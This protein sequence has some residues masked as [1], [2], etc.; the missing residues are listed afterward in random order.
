MSL[1]KRFKIAVTLDG[2]VTIT[3]PDD[4]LL[5]SQPPMLAS[6]PQHLAR[7]SEHP[8]LYL[9]EQQDFWERDAFLGLLCEDGQDAGEIWQP[10]HNI[11]KT[12]THNDGDL[13]AM[14]RFLFN[15]LIGDAAWKNIEDLVK[16]NDQI[17]LSLIFDSGLEA[18]HR[19]NWELMYNGEFLAAKRTAI[20]RLVKRKDQRK[21]R[22]FHKPPRI[23]F[24]VGTRYTDKRIR[25]G[26]EY[27]ALM[28]QLEAKG[29]TIHSRVLQLASTTEIRAEVD[30]FEPDAV[31]YICHG[32]L[33]R[34]GEGILRGCLE[35]QTENKNGTVNRFGKEILDD[36]KMSDD[37]PP[38][39][40]LSACDSGTQPLIG[41]AQTGSLAAELVAGG[42]PFV[43]GMGG[44]IS[45]MA[46]RL[47]TRRFGEA[48]ISGES[49]VAATAEGRRAAFLDR[50]PETIDWAYPTLFVG[51]DIEANYKPVNNDPGERDR[52][53]VLNKRLSTYGVPRYPVFCARYNFFERF[54]D[55]FAKSGRRVM[56]IWTEHNRQGLGRT[57]LLKEL[58]AQALRE[59][60]IPVLV[61]S[62]ESGW[63]PR[64]LIQFAVAFLRAI[65]TAR[66]AFDLEPKLDSSLLNLLLLAHPYPEYEKVKQL[67]DPETLFEQ[68]LARF[69]DTDEL[70]GAK[71]VKSAIRKELTDLIE[72][73][74]QL[75]N[76]VDDKTLAV[77]LLDQVH[78]YGDAIV[79]LFRVLID[80]FG[81]GTKD[82]PA[83]T[84]VCYSKGPP[85]DGSLREATE[86]NSIRWW[87]EELKPFQEDYE[88]MLAYEQVMLYPDPSNEDAVSLTAIIRQQN[89]EIEST[90]ASFAYNRRAM[91]DV[92]EKWTDK[93]RRRLGG[94]P[95]RL[96][97]D[98]MYMTIEDA[99]DADFLIAADD[100]TKLIKLRGQ[101]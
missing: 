45:D 52:G 6:I 20:T 60:H 84:V 31:H 80:D 15:K 77:V 62:K 44:S 69:D 4:Q 35:L 23:L 10:Y 29:L 53:E 24:V 90:I 48:M 34:D 65:K 91:A 78:E 26:A 94:L 18:L 66:A 81:M 25:P 7:D 21:P 32:A 58:A 47:F 3:G 1:L 100:D 67:L 63:E 56:T 36:L 93:F 73:I 98:T 72:D 54:R 82:Q 22:T 68:V 37:L 92:I 64:N 76:K 70:V 61:T 74:G 95:G 85:A 8:A 39:V 5:M 96:G 40:V 17:E 38:I 101:K 42:I 55:L 97:S 12:K 88:D 2:R 30:S 9:S 33:D 57:R 59:G 28:R 49:L 11:Y 43:V 99:Y 71:A 14:G 41:P 83:P 87:Q 27:F 50:I 79:P 13:K 16:K 86:G 89:A 51:A 19:F 46:C 75:P